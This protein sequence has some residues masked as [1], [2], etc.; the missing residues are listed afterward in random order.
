MPVIPALW[1]SEVGRSRGQEIKTILA[2]MRNPVSTKNTKIS[3]AQWRLSVVPT[4][5]EAEAGES[6]EPGR[7]RLQM[8]CNGAISVHCNFYLLGSTGTTGVCHHYWL[9]FAFLEEMGLHYV[10]RAGLKLLTTT[11]RERWSLASSPRLERSGLISAH[12]N[13]HLLSSSD[14]PASASRASRTTGVHH[15]TR[16]IFLFLVE[17]GFH[18]NGQAG[19]ELLT[20][21]G[22]LKSSLRPCHLTVRDTE[23]QRTQHF[24]KLRQENPLK[25]L[26]PTWP[27]WQNPVSTK[28][29]KKLAGRGGMCLQSQLPGRLRKQNH[30]NQ[31]GEISERF[32]PRSRML[33]P[34][35]LL[36]ARTHPTAPLFPFHKPRASSDMLR[37]VPFSHGRTAWFSLKRAQY[38]NGAATIAS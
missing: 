12:Y 32:Y 38:A 27:T 2:N 31:G 24:G 14:S 22:P 9:I 25:S 10:G 8:E 3:W 30:L 18:H 21:E 4:T 7:R 28:N 34:V 20:S 23:A 1:E 17:P 6:L 26:R 36:G 11:S 35:A 16:P 5:Q 19:L 37:H 13:L 29:T 33:K 15:Y